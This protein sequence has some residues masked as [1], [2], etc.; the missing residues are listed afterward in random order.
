VKAVRHF[1][2]SLRPLVF[3]DEM[4]RTGIRI[5]SGGGGQKLYLV[6]PDLFWS[7]GSS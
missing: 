3:R 2:G 4:E 5:V 7:F 6:F 1:T